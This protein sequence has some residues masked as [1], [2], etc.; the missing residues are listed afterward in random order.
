MIETLRLII[1]PLTCD[2]LVKQLTA[3][4]ELAESLGLKPSQSLADR[5]AQEAML[6]DLLPL[7]SDPDNNPLFY[8]MWIVIE[9]N[10]KAIIGGICFHGEPD[11]SGEVEIGYGTDEEYRN[12][13]YMS[14]TIAGLLHWAG[15]QKSI[16]TIKAETDKVNVASVRV[17]EK[18]NFVVTGQTDTAVIMKYNFGK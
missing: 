7:L 5:E 11:H 13:G 8:T 4:E 15:G 14:E 2:E 6:H 9:K 1:R 3:P 18:N 17:L 12:R 10:V 16:N